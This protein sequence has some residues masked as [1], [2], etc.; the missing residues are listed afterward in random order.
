MFLQNSWIIS[1][2]LYFPSYYLKMNII[3]LKGVA[4]VSHLK[5]CVSF[6]LVIFFLSS[7]N[8]HWKCQSISLVI[9]Y[10]PSYSVYLQYAM[11]QMFAVFSAS[12]RPRTSF[13]C[14]IHIA[15]LLSNENCTENHPCWNENRVD[16]WILE[17][18]QV[19][20]FSFYCSEI[21]FQI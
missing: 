10:I 8:T 20:L 15:K 19:Y 17:S 9:D 5:F 2:K 13:L 16:K 11:F 21:C 4:S 3:L 1:L 7:V 14:A 6:L 18:K 12:I